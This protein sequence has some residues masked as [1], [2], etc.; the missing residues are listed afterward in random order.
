MPTP[1]WQT[2]FEAEAQRLEA[3]VA[4]RR[5]V[6][7]ND[8]VAA[9]IDFA[10]RALRKRIAELAN[11]Q[12]LLT[13]EQW[14]ANQPRRVSGQAVRRWIRQRE[15]DAVPTS[16]GSLVP[17]DA[18]R[19]PRGSARVLVAPDAHPSVR[20]AVASQ[21]DASANTTEANSAAA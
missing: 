19:V 5:Q 11:A 6:V 10:A 2:V 14:G 21:L 12:L 7:E 16:R 13:P 1:L 3:E 8:P 4:N 9:G 18:V 20:A 17:A 15:L